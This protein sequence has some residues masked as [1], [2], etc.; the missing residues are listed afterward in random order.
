MFLIEGFS[1]YHLF[2]QSGNFF[3]TN[4]LKYYCKLQSSM[5]NEMVYFS[6]H[7]AASTTQMSGIT[8]T[9]LLKRKLKM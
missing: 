5:E 2:L 1:C 4:I 9:K 7:K 6:I 3:Q 8:F